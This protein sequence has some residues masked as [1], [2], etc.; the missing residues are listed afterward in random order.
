MTLA[1]VC[2]EELIIEVSAMADGKHYRSVIS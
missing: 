2:D 1:L